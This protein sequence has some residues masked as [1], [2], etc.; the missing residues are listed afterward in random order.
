MNGGIFLWMRQK[1]TKILGFTR[2]ITL[3]V[4][5][6]TSLTLLEIIITLDMFKV[7]KQK[8]LAIPI[9]LAIP[10]VF[11]QIGVSIVL[12]IINQ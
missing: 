3:L 1:S 8:I 4:Q 12:R 6:F 9:I 10:V 7:I 2:R 5:P 11:K